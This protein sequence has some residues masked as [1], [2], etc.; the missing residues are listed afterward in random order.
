MKL[1]ELHAEACF[2]GHTKRLAKKRSSC[3]KR[4]EVEKQQELWLA[5]NQYFLMVYTLFA[6]LS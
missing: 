4:H 5:G 6:C 2:Q 3:C 1:F